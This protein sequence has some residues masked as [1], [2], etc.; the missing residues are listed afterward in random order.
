V[1][2]SAMEDLLS[3]IDCDVKDFEICL[4]HRP[5]SCIKN[6]RAKTIKF[7]GDKGHFQDVIVRAWGMKKDYSFD[8]VDV[9]RALGLGEE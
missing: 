7:S 5:S 9:K 8:K 3:R 1:K 6:E 4:V 2:E